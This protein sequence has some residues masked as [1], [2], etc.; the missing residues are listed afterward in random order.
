MGTPTR[1]SDSIT[2]QQ[3][4]AYETSR[5]KWYKFYGYVVNLKELADIFGV[6]HV[7]FLARLKAGWPIEAALTADT[8]T[9]WTINNIKYFMSNEL[10]VPSIVERLDNHFLPPKSS[11]VVSGKKG[12]TK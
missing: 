12:V 9:Q 5:V 8:T 10:D 11:K 4:K 6:P 3:A 1:P 7:T 2:Y